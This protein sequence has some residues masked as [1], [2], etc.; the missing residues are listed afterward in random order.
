MIEKKKLGALVTV[1]SFA[2]VVA[3]FG[4]IPLALLWA[5]NTLFGVGLPYSLRTWGAMSVLL[6]A[7][8]SLR[9]VKS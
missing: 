6:F 1:V 3:A 2:L 7:G 9:R 8:A 4:L 5:L